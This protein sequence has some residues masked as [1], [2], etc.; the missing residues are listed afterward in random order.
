MKIVLVILGAISLGL[1]IAGIFLPLL[2]TTPLLLLSAWCFVRSSPRLYEWLINHPHLGPYIRNFREHRAIPLRVKVVSVTLVWLT[3]GYCIVSVC[4]GMI[5]LQI[6]LFAMAA[7][8]TY[9]ILSY[10]TLKS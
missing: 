7:A 5:W 2:P 6:L 8:I 9:H 4:S 1:A 3:I 10:K